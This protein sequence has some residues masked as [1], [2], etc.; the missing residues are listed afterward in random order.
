MQSFN[1]AI[2]SRNLNTSE[3]YA[4]FDSLAPVP[5]EFMLGSWRGEDFPTQHKLDGFLEAYH[6]YGKSFESTEHVHPLVFSRASGAHCRVNP[7]F[8][9]PTLWLIDRGYLPKNR[10]VTRLFQALLPLMSTRRSRARLRLTNFRGK[11][12]ATMIYDGLAIN[13]V[14]R[15]VDA[16]TVLGVMD[17]KNDSQDFF[18]VLRRLV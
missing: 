2:A 17:R 8:M 18:F 10:I 3:A 1:E 5:L 6:W 14:F 15:M 16:D 4:L 13:D 7:I 9:I 12:S 11:E